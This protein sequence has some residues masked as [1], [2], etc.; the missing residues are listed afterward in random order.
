MLR[1]VT[2]TPYLQPAFCAFRNLNVT[3]L[4]TNRH[5]AILGFGKC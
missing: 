5:F 1:N 2:R 4:S 3:M